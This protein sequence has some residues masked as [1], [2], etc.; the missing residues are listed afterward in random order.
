LLRASNRYHS[1]SVSWPGSDHRTAPVRDDPRAVRVDRDP[2][3]GL[4]LG[5]VPRVGDRGG[6][7]VQHEQPTAVPL[8][9]ESDPGLPAVRGELLADR[10][11]AGERPVEAFRI[12]VALERV[13][14]DDRAADREGRLAASRSSGISTSACVAG[15]AKPIT[16]TH[17]AESSGV[18]AAMCDAGPVGRTSTTSLLR[19][20]ITIVTAPAVAATNA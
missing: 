4:H 16:A 1:P 11:E 7:Q 9:P 10:L 13:A 15:S 14:H 2:A 6:L 19:A 18:T 5:R 8:G 12:E 17:T 3:V 20:S